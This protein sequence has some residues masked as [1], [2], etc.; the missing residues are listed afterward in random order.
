[1]QTKATGL[2]RYI[3]IVQGVLITVTATL[4]VACDGNAKKAVGGNVSTL[5][6][7]WVNSNLKTVVNS[8]NS[9]T[10]SWAPGANVA[11][12]RVYRSLNTTFD[13][14]YNSIADALSVVNY[15]DD[16]LDA[17]TTYYYLVVSINKDDSTTVIGRGT[18][19]TPA[20]D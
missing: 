16:K 11:Y 12:Y 18:A 17:G 6:A 3:G 15:D 19:T 14:Y 8:S 20:H 9:V 13:T 4:L 2:R 10:L 5:P 1:M 7:Q